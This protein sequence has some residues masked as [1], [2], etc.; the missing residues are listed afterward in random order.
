M[1]TLLLVLV[2]VLV[3]G[4]LVY[5]VVSLLSGDDPG[6][7]P[8]EP[9]G[10]ARPLPNDRSL[11]EDDLKEIR[12]DV[13]LRGYRMAQVDRMLRRVAYDLGY[14]DEMIAVLEAEVAALREG[15]LEDAELLRK[16]REAASTPERDSTGPDTTS[17]ETTSG[18]WGSP[19][20]VVDLGETRLAASGE[21]PDG[22][23]G[24]DGS[25]RTVAA[26]HD[27]TV[28]AEPELPR[29]GSLRR[30]EPVAADP[31]DVADVAAQVDVADVAVQVDVADVAA[32]EDAADGAPIMDPATVRAGEGTGG[33]SAV[34]GADRPAHA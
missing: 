1:A 24:E 2:V 31:L 17:P 29:E 12:F 33:A 8:A 15:R 18:S 19:E 4:G 23:A 22:R 34:D 27:R 30:R 16:A 20:P 26:D 7:V 28:P 3:I 25:D 5:G 32:N 6:L 14:K 21:S 10:R 11:H 13:A 9:D